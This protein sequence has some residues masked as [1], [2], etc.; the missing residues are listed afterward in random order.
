L[1]SPDPEPT[2]GDIA[3]LASA[4]ESSP[5]VVVTDDKPVRR[6][7]RAL[8]V[9]LSGSIGVVIAAVERGDM[10]RNEAKDTLVAMDEIGARLSARLLRRAERLVD[11]AAERD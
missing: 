9:P 1:G 11:A 4:L 10:E 3:L 7:C 5:V 2:S 8:G 6:A